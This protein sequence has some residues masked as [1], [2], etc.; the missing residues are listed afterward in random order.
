MDWTRM[1]DSLIENR[2]ANIGATL[3]W[4]YPLLVIGSIYLTWLV[5][6]IALGHRPIPSLDDPKFI[7]VWVDIPLIVS[8]FLMMGFVFAL[9]SGPAAILWLGVNWDLSL[10]GLVVLIFCWIFFWGVAT[11]ILDILPR[12]IITWYMD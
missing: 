6:W 4:C 2:W 5:A 11:L 7:S 1:Q 12:D 8:R 10:K 3:I 9:G